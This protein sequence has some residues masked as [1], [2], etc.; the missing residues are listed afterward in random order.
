MTCALNKLLALG[1]LAAALLFAPAA[2]SPAQALGAGLQAVAVKTEAVTAVHYRRWHHRHHYY[3]YRYYRYHH[4]H[5]YHHRH[6]RRVYIR[7][8]I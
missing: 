5:R 3:G 2:K 8:Y 6:H 7:V 1:M 4:Y